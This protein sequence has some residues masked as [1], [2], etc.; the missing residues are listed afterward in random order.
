MTTLGIIIGDR[1]FPMAHLE[2]RILGMN[3][4]KMALR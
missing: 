3:R 2:V 1:G 4:R